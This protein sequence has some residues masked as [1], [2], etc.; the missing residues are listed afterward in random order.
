MDLRHIDLQSI[1]LLQAISPARGVRETLHRADRH[2]E[3]NVL[4]HFIDLMVTLN[5]ILG[6]FECDSSWVLYTQF[7]YHIGNNMIPEYDI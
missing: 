1:Q 5:L 4:Q 7:V 2:I 3:H 6:I